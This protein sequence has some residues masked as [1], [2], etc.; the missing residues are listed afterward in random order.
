MPRAGLDCALALEAELLR[1]GVH[2]SS[3]FRSL[4]TEC[5]NKPQKVP[6]LCGVLC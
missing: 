5:K 1:E 2:M 4:C 6:G 3:E